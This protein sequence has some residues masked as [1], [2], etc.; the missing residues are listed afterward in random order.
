MT[1]G[2]FRYVLRFYKRGNMR[3]ISHLDLQ[4]LFK[5]VL[6]R[7]GIDVDFTK[8]FNPHPKINIVQPLSLGF[9]SECEYF[10]MECLS[11]QDTE[12]LCERLNAA[13]PAGLAFTGCRRIPLDKKNLSAFTFAAEYI[14]DLPCSPFETGD[15]LAQETVPVLKR[16]KKTKAMVEKDAKPL[17]ISVSQ[18]CATE[19]GCRCVMILRAASNETLN[20]LNLAEAMLRYKGIGYVK[21]DIRIT[22]T[23]I[24]GQKGGGLVPVCDIF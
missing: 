17:I 13:M 24:Y 19:N 12:T 8:G 3:F 7:A 11:E 4:R 21:E 18:P 9:E 10:E 16:D 14:V 23:A 22:R 15:I 6:Y 20:P 1:E 5:R 2:N